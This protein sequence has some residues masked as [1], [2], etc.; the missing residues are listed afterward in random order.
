M[1]VLVIE[2]SQ[3]PPEGLELDEP[4]D[5]ASVHVEREGDFSLD[6]GGRLRARVELVDGTSIHVRGHLSAPLHLECGRCLESFPLRLEQDLDLFYLP[7]RSD[8]DREEEDEV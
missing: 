1:G 5:A 2:I 8:D 3:I 7:H 4:L 6:P